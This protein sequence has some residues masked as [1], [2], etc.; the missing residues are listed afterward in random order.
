[1]PLAQAVAL[2]VIGPMMGVIGAKLLLKEQL[3]WVKGSI[4]LASFSGACVLM[5]PGSALLANKSNMTGLLFLICSSLFFALAKLATR[6]LALQGESVKTLTAYLFIFIVPVTFIPALLHWVTPD[7]VHWPW[8]II[9]GVLTAMA[10]YCVSSALVYAQVSFLA[11]F[12][13]CQFILNTIVGYVAFMELPAPW[14]IWLL[15]AFV[16]FS[17]TARKKL[18]P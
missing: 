14:A 8:L 11:P 5:Q 15:L 12:D 3:G 6:K 7:W 4:I 1:M 10:I 13:I 2:S 18:N 17:M 9:A 16:G